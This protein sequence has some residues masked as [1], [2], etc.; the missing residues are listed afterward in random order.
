MIPNETLHIEPLTQRER[1]M[2]QAVARGLRNRQ[3]AYEF[4]IS[5]ETV[6]KHLATIYGKLAISGR[7]ALA[8][9]VM[10]GGI[11]SGMRAA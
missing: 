4:G 11:D 8:V 9:L 7:V 10:S 2:A 3:I 1:Q 5:E 6:K